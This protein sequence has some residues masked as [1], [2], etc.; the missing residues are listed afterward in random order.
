V[1]V[2]IRATRPC[3]LTIQSNFIEPSGNPEVLLEAQFLLNE[4]LQRQMEDVQGT[5]FP[6]TSPGRRARPSGPGS[7][8]I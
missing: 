6:K 3:P 1:A 4:V 2:T 5:P 7:N 8:L